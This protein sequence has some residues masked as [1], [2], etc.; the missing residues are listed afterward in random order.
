MPTINI[1]TRPVGEDCPVYIIAEMSANHNQDYDRAVALVHAA[2][3]AGADAIKLQTYTPDSLTIDSDEKWF[4]IK[5]NTWQGQSLYE[6][7]GEAYT[8]WQWQPKLQAVARA[9]GLDFFATPFDSSAVDFLEE[10]EVPVHKVASFELVDHGL[11]R[12]IAATAKPVILSTGMARLAE[13]TEAVA[14][15]RDCGTTEIAL[16]KCTS[17]YPAQAEDMNLR[18]MTHLAETFSVPV[19]LSDHSMGLAIPVAAVALGATIIEKHLTLSRQD[20]GLDSGF[21]LEPQEFKEMV[22]AIR[23][24]EQALGRVQ[25]DLTAGEQQS[26]IFRRSLFVV[27]DMD[28][29]ACFT[30]QN[31][32]SI[33]PGYGL[34]PKYYADLLGQRV[35]RCVSRGTP[36]DWQMVEES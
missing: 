9:V 7:Y 32:R 4:Q 20:K 13:I 35:G 25:Y 19:G 15:L 31:L 29:G 3:E 10:L 8:P 17:A 22:Q 26:L 24:T 33:R 5:K 34:A 18:T 23:T 28:K 14:V 6:L 27:E 1:G 16:L 36:V 2:H 12:K 21:S 11:L 30:R